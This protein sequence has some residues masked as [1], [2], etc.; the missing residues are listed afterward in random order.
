[1]TGPNLTAVGRGMT[2]ELI[3]ESLLWPRR[4]IKEGYF[5]ST[6]TTHDGKLLSG[7]KV[8]EDDKSLVLR[9]LEPVRVLEVSLS[10]RVR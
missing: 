8:S 9:S 1:M 3:T 4:Q 5:L 2:P 6:V 10:A 7:Y